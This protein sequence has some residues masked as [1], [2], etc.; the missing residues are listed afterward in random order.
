M[1]ARKGR[2]LR[3]SRHRGL[4]NHDT[5]RQQVDRRRFQA[6]ASFLD[7]D[8]PHAEFEVAE[9]FSHQH[10]DPSSS[11]SA[12]ILAVGTPTPQ[13]E[14][15]P[16]RSRSALQQA[17]SFFHDEVQKPSW[18]SDETGYKYFVAWHRGGQLPFP[19]GNN[20]HTAFSPTV[21]ATPP[22]PPSP[23][24]LPD[25][26]RTKFKHKVLIPPFK[27]KFPRIR[28]PKIKFPK[29]KF[30]K[31]P[32]IP[33][34]PPLPNLCDLLPGDQCPPFPFPLAL[35]NLPIPP[36]WFSLPKLPPKGMLEM[37]LTA[38]F[39]ASLKVGFFKGGRRWSSAMRFFIHCSWTAVGPP[40]P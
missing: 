17:T 29:I 12:P 30:P 19:P 4:C 2:K 16:T 37:M 40:R 5:S 3:V 33:P 26:S 22:P 23:D 28:F 1:S 18:R 20:H 34:I 9:R 11:S 21:E 13:Q 31:F 39:L 7:T 35:P 36:P 24:P 15:H 27:F 6:L 32:K 38:V 25:Y 14:L 10:H 8:T